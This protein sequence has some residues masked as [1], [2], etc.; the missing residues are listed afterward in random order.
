MAHKAALA[1]ALLS[2]MIAG[3]SAHGA[4]V[5]PRTR[6]SVDYLVGVNS[7]KDWPAPLP[8]D[9]TTRVGWRCLS[10]MPFIGRAR[11][12]SSGHRVLAWTGN[13][14]SRAATYCSMVMMYVPLNTVLRLARGTFGNYVFRDA[15][16]TSSPVCRPFNKDCTHIAADSVAGHPSPSRL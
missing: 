15:Y 7:P 4:V 14:V 2:T 13:V 3:A 9:C 1:C 5:T 16:K 12:P 6:N 11:V 10:S 8:R